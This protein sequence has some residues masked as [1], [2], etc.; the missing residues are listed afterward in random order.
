MTTPCSDYGRTEMNLLKTSPNADRK[1]ITTLTE[2]I[3]EIISDSGEGAQRCGQ[4][5]GSI[6]ARM[7][8]GI[9]TTEIIPAEIRPPARSVAGASGNRIRIGSGYITN[10]GD[11]TDLVVAFNEQVLLG[12]VR[13]RELKPGCIIFLENMWRKHTDLNISMA[14]IEAHDRLVAAG[15]KVIEFPMEQECKLLNA[16]PKRGKNM[17]ALGML[18]YLYSFDLQMARDQIALTF[19]KKEQ[20]VIDANVKLLEAGHQ[21][22]EAHLDFCFSV[23]ATPTSQSQ[24][25]V[26][27]NTALAL[28]VMASGMDLCSMYPITPATSASHYLSDV[29]EKVGGI[30]HQAEDEIAAC[31]FAI[32]ASY[33]SKCTVT[34]TSGPGYS[35]KQEAI[36]LAVMAEIPLVV[37]NVQRGGPSTGQPTK[38]EQ[39]DLMCAIFGSHGDAPKVVMAAA[40]IEDCFYAVITARKI[41]EAFNM[42]VVILTDASLSS[43]QQPF[44]RP[45]F[46]ASWLAPPFDQSPIPE[47]ARAY[48]WDASTGLARRFVP[49]QPGGM[50]T[51]TGLAHDRDSHVAY[52]P[53]INQEGL[54]ARSLKLAALQKTLTPPEVFGEASGD[55]LVVGWGSTKGA[56]EE[57]VASLRSE[58]RKVSSI[59]LRFLQPMQPGIKEIMQ[60]FGKVMTIETN[61]SDKPDEEIIDESNRRYSSLAVLLRSR[62]LIDVDCWSEVR[63]QPVKP[64]T[65]RRVLLAKLDA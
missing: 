34:I 13:A 18:C 56:I 45:R 39:G 53:D 19:G 6:A 43:S 62:C 27:G 11:E 1:S 23:P 51:V 3:V 37:V 20:A 47:G 60:R 59:H 54:R 61:W 4:S 32:G 52:D 38:V 41:A 26:N 29:F 64:S 24:I 14:Y 25:V 15:Y 5:L 21:W 42:V 17:F 28:G 63:G 36:G 12:R 49:G 16:D 7:G 46:N 65:I 44:T 48:N 10:G 22:G 2:H 58:G 8:N 40:T 35:L 33:A 57:A 55:L 31:A 50:H 9:W 30:V